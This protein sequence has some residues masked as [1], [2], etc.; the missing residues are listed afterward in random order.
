MLAGRERTV[1]ALGVWLANTNP[2]R[3]LLRAPRVSAGPDGRERTVSVPGVWLANTNP[4]LD[5][6]RALI[7]QPGNI[8]LLSIHTRMTPAR[9]VHLARTRQTTGQSVCCV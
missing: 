2:I 6:L 9:T 8:R 4:I 7:A 5:L 3:G 1:S